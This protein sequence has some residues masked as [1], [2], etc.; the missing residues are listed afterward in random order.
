MTGLQIMLQ[1][2]LIFERLDK[3]TP[4]D[5]FALVAHCGTFYT[6]LLNMIRSDPNRA[7]SPVTNVNPRDL[8]PR[9]SEAALSTRRPS[10]KAGFFILL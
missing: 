10:F 3:N 9:R 2:N 7:I 4:A 6:V 5:C 1:L 8:T